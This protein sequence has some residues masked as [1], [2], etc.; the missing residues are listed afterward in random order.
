VIWFGTAANLKRIKSVD[1][2]LQVSGGIIQPVNVVCDLGVLLDQELSMKQ[3]I[4]RQTSNCFYQIRRL[5]QVRRI[6]GPEIT[7][8]FITAFVTSRLD[9]CNAVLADLPKSTVAPLQRVQNAVACLTTKIGLRDHVTP[10]LQQLH[11]LPIPFRATDKLC[12]LMHQVHTGRSPPYLSNLVTATADLT[13]REALRS[14]NS[15]RYEVH[16][17]N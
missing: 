6:L 1:L 12:V 14:S 3:H 4:N 16:E 8:S 9:Q 2:A 10:T 11:W 7:T 15:L 13:S 5:K 17:R